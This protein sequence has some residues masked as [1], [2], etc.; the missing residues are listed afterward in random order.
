MFHREGLSGKTAFA[1]FG[2]EYTGHLQGDY[3]KDWSLNLLLLLFEPQ[4]D[5]TGDDFPENVFP[6]FYSLT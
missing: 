4:M 6:G 2:F 1:L 5:N 3:M